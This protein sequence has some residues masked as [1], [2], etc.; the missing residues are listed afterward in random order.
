MYLGKSFSSEDDHNAEI[1][2]LMTE[3]EFKKREN[4]ELKKDVFSKESQL[5]RLAEDHV[6]TKLGSSLIIFNGVLI[7]QLFAQLRPY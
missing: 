5:H 4:E 6:L 2:R 3:L 7:H 1:H